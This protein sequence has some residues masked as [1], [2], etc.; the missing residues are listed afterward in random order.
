MFARP[1]AIP[2]ELLMKPAAAI[3]VAT[4]IERRRAKLPHPIRDRDRIGRHGGRIRSELLAKVAE[5]TEEVSSRLL[6]RASIDA[7]VAATDGV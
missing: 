6:F 4:L 2:R 5:P 7:E 3:G 1:A